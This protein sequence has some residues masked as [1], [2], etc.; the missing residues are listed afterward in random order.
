MQRS[1]SGSVVSQEQLF[2]NGLLISPI[3]SDAHQPL[4]N[5]HNPR[6]SRDAGTYACIAANS[7]LTPRI[8]IARFML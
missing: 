6:E 4:R 1:L 8:D 2:F 7:G 5:P 3:R